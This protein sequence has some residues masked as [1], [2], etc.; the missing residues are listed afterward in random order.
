[1]AE[2]VVYVYVEKPKEI[3][4]AMLLNCL[5]LLSLGWGHLY[6]GF[7]GAFKM[8]LGIYW[9]GFAIQLVVATTSRDAYVVMTLISLIQLIVVGFWVFSIFDV[10]NKMYGRALESNREA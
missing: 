9:V 7:R 6:A 1:M 3:W 4:I 2:K 8:Y 10:A 5:P